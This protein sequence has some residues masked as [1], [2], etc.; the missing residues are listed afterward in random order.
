MHGTDFMA[1]RFSAFR[2][3]SIFLFVLALPPASAV[4]G[5]L[6]YVTN[7]DADTV[8]VID[9]E[10]GAVVREV[11]V[12]A[13]PCD[14]AI[15]PKGE[16]IAVSHEERR[17]EVSF[18]NRKDLSIKSKTLLVEAEDGRASCFFLAFG[19]ESNKLYAA[20]RYSGSLFVVDVQNARVAKEISLTH[21]KDFRLEGAV[22]SPDGA[23]L[24]LPNSVGSEILV[25][26]AE[27]DKPLEPIT[28]EGVASAVAFSPDGGRL[29]VANGQGPS[30]D[31]IDIKTRAVIKRIPV[32]N[33]PVG[34]AVSK[35]GS[36]IFVS[37]KMSYDVDKIDV[38]LLKKTANIPVGMYPY[39]IA[40][41]DDGKKVYVCNYNENT[42]SI[43]DAA[44]AKEILRVATSFTPLKIAVYSAP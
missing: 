29:Y 6:L 17:G 26:D 34:I 8:S 12:G 24:Y 33:Q 31:V 11:K 18:L 28:V 21:G 7:I 4:A 38:A 23:L 16:L 10:K 44:S 39:G 42:V 40:V 3:I 5:D 41:S 15:D 30:L 43:I 36:F 1:L 19:R 22:L 13:D 9:V 37:N 32:G 35:D 14:I 25:V 27:M 2:P 20:N